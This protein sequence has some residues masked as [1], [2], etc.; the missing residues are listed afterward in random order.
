MAVPAW[1]E[2]PEENYE[3]FWG[4]FT[5]RFRFQPTQRAPGPAI[6]E[7]TPSVTLDLDSIFADPG[8]RFA[9][10]QQ[11]VNALALL[12]MTH[13]FPS[14]RLLVL[15]W[16]HQSWWFRPDQQAVADEQSWPVEVFPNGDYYAFLTEDMNEG[17][18]GHP[19]EHTLCVFGDRLMPRLVPALT[20]WLPVK[21]S[22]Q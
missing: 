17:T 20:S 9:A 8:P 7:P 12:A 6:Q 14:R 3:D 4:P 22:R 2:I 15:D 21:G 13:A 16:Q 5:E 1:E 10:G 19:W 18:F 11:A